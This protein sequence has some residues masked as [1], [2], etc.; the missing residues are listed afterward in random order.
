VL[1]VDPGFE[2]DRGLIADLRVTGQ[3]SARI[4][5]FDQLVE[6]AEALPGADRACAINHVPLDNNGSSMTYVPWGATYDDRVRALPIGVTDGCFEVLRVTLLAGRPFA[7]S[8]TESVAILSESTAEALFPGAASVLDKQIHLGVADGPALRVIGVAED[9]HA[10]S[11]EERGLGQ[12]WTSVSRGWPQPERLIVRTS[13]PPES[14]ATPLRDILRELNPDLAL[15]NVRTMSDIVGNA[16]ASRRFVLVLLGGFAAIAVALCVVGIYGVLSHQVGQRTREIG[17][18]LALGAGARQVM[19]LVTR[20]IVAAVLAGLAVGAAGA[21]ALS[22]ILATQLF[23]MSATD[24]RVYAGVAV[25]VALVSAAAALP[26]LRRAI[27]I[28]PLTALRE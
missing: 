25:F 13:A 27:K 17:I 23:E 22:S 15:A 1:S 11:L 12:V 4:G 7:Q 28:E 9:M 6:R 24:A 18:R 21:W 16:T 8:E 5:L 3:T 2:L 10:G 26:P 14:L 20:Q 19:T